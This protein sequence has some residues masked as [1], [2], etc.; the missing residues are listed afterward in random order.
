MDILAAIREVEQ[1]IEAA[2]FPNRDQLAVDQAKQEADAL[3][4]K[5]VRRGMT[6]DER[7][8]MALMLWTAERA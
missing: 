2:L 4:E 6:D 5:A 7:R 8:A 3:S 1:K